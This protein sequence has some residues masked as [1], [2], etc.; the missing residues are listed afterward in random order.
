MNTEY[1]L[2]R[3]LAS[4]LK[5][6]APYVGIPI[7]GHAPLIFNRDKLKRALSGV[8]PIYIAVLI[9]DNGNRSLTVEGVAGPRCRTSLRMLS[10]PRS[11]FNPNRY[12]EPYMTMQKWNPVKSK[13]RVHSRTTKYDKAIAKLERQLAKLG[14]RPHICNPSLAHSEVSENY[15]EQFLQWHRQKDL[16][17]K[18]GYLGVQ[19][20]AGKLTA[21]EL[22]LALSKLTTVKRY[23]DFTK[24]QLERMGIEI[25]WKHNGFFDYCDPKNLWKFL[26][27]V[28]NFW[29][30]SRPKLCWGDWEAWEERDRW[31]SE[32]Y[33]PVLEWSHRRQ[34]LLSQIA[35]LHAITEDA[36]NA[37][38]SRSPD[39]GL[40]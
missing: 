13:P 11:V 37:P 20:H 30:Q 9:H 33:A 6:S 18:I 2:A 14:D 4:A 5:A 39:S 38:N 3:P 36:K 1:D 21:H 34:E 29:Q 35:A 16:R 26:P 32:R 24:K 27:D 12:S 23:S 7:P 17:R 40:R 31:G 8:K 28:N 15:R 22:Y 10:L 19:T 25:G